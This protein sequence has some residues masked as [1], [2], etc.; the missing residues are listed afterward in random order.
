MLYKSPQNLLGGS[1]IL[2]V[3]VLAPTLSMGNLISVM[4]AQKKLK[5]L[6][7]NTYSATDNKHFYVS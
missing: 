6:N 3:R 7:K 4:N 1:T 2:R 5:C